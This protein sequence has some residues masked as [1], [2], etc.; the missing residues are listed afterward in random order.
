MLVGSQRIFSLCPVKKKAQSVFRR[1]GATFFRPC[2]GTARSVA[3]RNVAQNKKE[4]QSSGELLTS[5]DEVLLYIDLTCIC[6]MA[7]RCSPCFGVRFAFFFDG[8]RIKSH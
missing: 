8:A 1:R 2:L 4:N 5:H 6:D 3:S 7:H